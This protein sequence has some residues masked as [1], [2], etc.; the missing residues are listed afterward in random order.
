[1]RELRGETNRNPTME[2]DL[3]LSSQKIEEQKILQG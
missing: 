3:L 2:Y 1:M